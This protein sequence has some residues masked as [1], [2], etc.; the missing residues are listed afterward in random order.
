M[1]RREI[2]LIAFGGVINVLT[3]AFN[4]GGVVP[5]MFGT[6]FLVYA[7]NGGELTVQRVFTTLSLV[8]F[9]RRVTLLFMVR[10][11]FLLYEASIANTRIQVSLCICCIL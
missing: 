11:F 6:M 3:A 5:F 4:F 2:K 1:C 10:C 8:I 9:L 7:G